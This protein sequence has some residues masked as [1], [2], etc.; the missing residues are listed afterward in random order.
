MRISG[1]VTL[2]VGWHCHGASGLRSLW[3]PDS[4]GNEENQLCR[5]P[6]RASFSSRANCPDVGTK[7]MVNIGT[8]ETSDREQDA[9]RV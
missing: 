2:S 4:Q 7:R 5:L 8:G 6:M 9:G 1:L 3:R